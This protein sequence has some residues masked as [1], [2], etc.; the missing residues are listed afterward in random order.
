MT[1]FLLVGTRRADR[2]ELS[3][4]SAARDLLAMTTWHGWLRR[5]G[6]LRAFAVAT[7]P[8]PVLRACLV[9]RASNRAAAEEL[10]T[11]WGCL[12]GYDVAVLALTDTAS[13]NPAQP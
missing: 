13:R 6:L 3:P 8:W 5:W 9:V 7:E 12:G 2:G 11:G 10:A 1:D 4:A